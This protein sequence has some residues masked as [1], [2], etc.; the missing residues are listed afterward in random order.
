MDVSKIKPGDWCYG[1]RCTAC[2]RAIAVWPDLSQAQDPIR[3]S[4]TTSQ[5]LTC[6]DP[7]CRHVSVYRPTDLQHFK[8]VHSQTIES[9]SLL[10]N[11]VGEA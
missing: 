4:A 3:F 11:H 8:A 2:G 5:T 6:P 9:V 7:R 1:I 10:G